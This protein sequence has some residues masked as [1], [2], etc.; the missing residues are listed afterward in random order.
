MTSTAER[1]RLIPESKRRPR[2][3]T[4]LIIVGFAAAATLSATVVIAQN[5]G[6]AQPA[7]PG[8]Q[9][10]RAAGGARAQAAPT[11]AAC[12]PNNGL[13][14]AAND[15][16][17]FELR[18]YTFNP[19]GAIGNIDLLHERFRKATMAQFKKHDITMIGF[20]QPIG[21][22]DTLV[23]LLAYKNAAARDASWAAFQADP[24]WIKART[25]MNVSLTVENEFM[26]A[27][28]YSQLK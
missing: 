11:S 1:S 2:V 14:N 25:E 16:R 8:A 4:R 19:L 3:K 22:P 13:K 24:D 27:T 7:A 26:V 28:D 23:Y 17:C 10:G 21:K 12:G 15:S 5:A 6:G 9:G 18:R 20:W